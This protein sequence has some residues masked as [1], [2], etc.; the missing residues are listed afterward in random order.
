MGPYAWQI[1]MYGTLK[2][3]RRVHAHT[4][5]YVCRSIILS[6]YRFQPSATCKLLHG[7]RRRLFDTEKYS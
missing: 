2:F 3:S 4:M 1:G 6:R 7:Y 5:S